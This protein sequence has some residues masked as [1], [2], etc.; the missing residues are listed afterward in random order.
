[1]PKRR[2]P[3]PHG[4][5]IFKILAPAT[6]PVEGTV[7]ASVAAEKKEHFEN[8]DLDEEMIGRP[9]WWRLLITYLPW[10]QPVVQWRRY[11]DGTSIADDGDL[12]LSKSREQGDADLERGE[13]KDKARRQTW[14]TENTLHMNPPD[15]D[16]GRIEVEYEQNE[17]RR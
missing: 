17:R 1:M 16:V 8:N 13:S 6:K 4:K 15:E 9:L 2:L 7:P 11:R 5:N 10:L 12:G 3:V 14:N